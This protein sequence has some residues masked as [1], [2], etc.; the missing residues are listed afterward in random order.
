MYAV[1]VEQGRERF[2]VRR[3]SSGFLPSYRVY[4]GSSDGASVRWPVIPGYVFSLVMVRNAIVVP[5]VEWEIIDRLSDSRHSVI[6][7]EGKIV[8][9]P[10]A[11]LSHLV[12]K[13]GRDFVQIRVNL[14][15]EER[16]Y[17]L[18][19]DTVEDAEKKKERIG[20][21]QAEKAK[22]RSPEEQ[23]A[24][25]LKRAEE[26]GVHAA[27]REF[28]IAWQTLARIRRQA[29]GNA[30]TEKKTEPKGKTGRQKTVKAGVTGQAVTDL[31]TENAALRKQ[32][33]QLTAKLENLKKA[34]AGILDEV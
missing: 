15:G 10:L 7:A 16:T 14:L 23:S 11:E 1:K 34:L 32:V 3:I 20:S 26:V 21:P 31:K 29:A 27:A 30:G 17:H 13:T 8:S 9:G 6:N 28:D 2:E 33:E 4:S 18:L 19:C 25:M 24:A 12:V 5:E 22:A